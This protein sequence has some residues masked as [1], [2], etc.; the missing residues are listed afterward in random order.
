M[1][2]RQVDNIYKFLIGSKYLGHGTTGFCFLLP[3]GQV[4]KIYY[5]SERTKNF[6]SKHRSSIINF[7]EYINS[8]NSETFYG[9]NEI[10][11]KDGKVIGYIMNLAYGK[12]I[13]HMSSNITI[14]DI[15]DMITIL[16]RDVKLVSKDNLRICDR[17]QKNI[18]YSCIF[19]MV[20]LDDCYRN[21]I[22]NYDQLV[23]YNMG[24]LLFVITKSL[25]NVKDKCD[26]YFRDLDLDALFEK[27]VYR[28]YE[29]Y[30]TFLEHLRSFG[31][32]LGELRDSGIHYSLVH[33]DYYSKF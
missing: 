17:H 13:R 7:F 16:I 6:F 14:D 27:S 30:F 3:S 33:E 22:N 25:F 24:D 2:T 29:E 28:D 15:E 8:F 10:L 18:V 11:L 20:D 32:D 12:R 5:N 23:K 9:P 4:A 1:R 31:K 21:F 19:K 26:V